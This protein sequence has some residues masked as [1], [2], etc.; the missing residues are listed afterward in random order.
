MGHG[1]TG[2]GLRTKSWTGIC[3]LCTR[4]SH[5]RALPP[6]EWVGGLVKVFAPITPKPGRPLLPDSGWEQHELIDA[7]RRYAAGER[8]DLTREGE[9]IYHRERKR[10]QRA[11]QMQAEAHAEKEIA[12]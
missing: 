7:H 9:R 4:E 12:A 1:C 5:D 6:G 3:G 11:R 8:D 2:C 10:A